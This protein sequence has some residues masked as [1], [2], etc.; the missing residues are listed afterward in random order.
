[1]EETLDICKLGLFSDVSEGVL[2]FS[3]FFNV[4]GLGWGPGNWG[5]APF[6]ILPAQSQVPT[7]AAQ[8]P[9]S[10]QL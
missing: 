2:D 3:Y 9:Q 6:S 10:N 8:F 7:Q 4:R 5:Q 1:M